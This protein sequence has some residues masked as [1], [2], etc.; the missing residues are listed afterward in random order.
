MYINFS[1]NA[2]THSVLMNDD[3]DFQWINFN[4]KKGRIKNKRLKLLESK[5]PI[6]KCV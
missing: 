1:M 6:S 2:R 3:Y 5:N 4:M